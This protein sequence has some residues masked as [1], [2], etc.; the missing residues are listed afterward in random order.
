MVLKRVV[1]RTV[2]GSV[3]ASTLI[4]DSFQLPTKFLHSKQRHLIKYTQQLANE[5]RM[6]LG[7]KV[8][9]VVRIEKVERGKTVW[10]RMED[11]QTRWDK[12]SRKT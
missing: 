5:Y 6:V 9:L 7:R 11:I 12:E 8:K 1:A 10:D 4:L 2:L 3:N